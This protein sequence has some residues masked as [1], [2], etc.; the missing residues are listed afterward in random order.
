MLRMPNFVPKIVSKKALEAAWK[1]QKLRAYRPLQTF[2]CALPI[3]AL[4]SAILI[5]GGWVLYKSANMAEEGIVDY[6]EC[7][8][9]GTQSV[10]LRPG[11]IE[12]ND[13][14]ELAD[15]REGSCTYN[16]YVS[17]PFHVCFEGRGSRILTKI[18]CRLYLTDTQLL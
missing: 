6:T 13:Y 15:T 12:P 17:K 7:L 1:Q 9:N 18:F 10:S 2:R 16:I 14:Y 5:A 11:V 8:L 4:V 3:V